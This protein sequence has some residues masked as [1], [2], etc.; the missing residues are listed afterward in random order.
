M[1]A[2]HA[3]ARMCIPNTVSC[4]RMCSCNVWMRDPARVAAS[5]LFAVIELGMCVP[6]PRTAT[7]YPR[8]GCTPSP[9]TLSCFSAR[10]TVAAPARASL[11]RP[12]TA[13]QPL[14][15]LRGRPACRPVCRRPRLSPPLTPTCW[16]RWLRS[17]RPTSLRAKLRCWSCPRSEKSMLTWHRACGTPLGR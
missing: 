3:C 13:C 1:F 12:R 17:R 7:L 10:R 14:A 4:T 9:R 11:P 15:L 5:H 2:L 8:A 16:R 6:P